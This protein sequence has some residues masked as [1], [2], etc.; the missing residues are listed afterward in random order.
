[1]SRGL[2][3][4]CHLIGGREMAFALA[5]P[6]AAREAP[7]P[8]S[9]GPSSRR[10]PRVAHLSARSG[11]LESCRRAFRHVRRVRE[12]RRSSS[13]RSHSVAPTWPERRGGGARGRRPAAVRMPGRVSARR[14]VRHRTASL[15]A[16]A[17]RGHARRAA[18]Q[19]PPTRIRSSR[20]TAISSTPALTGG[21]TGVVLLAD[22]RGARLRFQHARRGGS[23]VLSAPGALTSS[24]KGLVAFEG[25]RTCQKRATSRAPHG[26]LDWS[27]G[28]SAPAGAGTW[29]SS[30]SGEAAPLRAG[31][32]PERLE[33]RHG[34]PNRLQLH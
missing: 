2:D 31:R 26:Q 27:V 23:R 11:P 20:A 14:R 33:R 15:R 3:L 19:L 32:R 5:C 13:P 17:R 25:A 8:I 29:A 18:V 12:C 4:R 30:R 22:S 6:R 1:M 34:V 21:A 7:L 24:F 10:A 9:L 28:T 16:R